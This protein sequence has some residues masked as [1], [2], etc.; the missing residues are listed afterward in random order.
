[1]K[2]VMTGQTQHLVPNVL[3]AYPQHTVVKASVLVS[4]VPEKRYSVQCG[5]SERVSTPEFRRQVILL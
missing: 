2:A 3:S 4:V 1:M 5:A